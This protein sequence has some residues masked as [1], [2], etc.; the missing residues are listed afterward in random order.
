MLVVKQNVD[1]VV[2]HDESSPQSQHANEK[3]RQAGAKRQL[4]NFK[5]VRFL[6]QENSCQWLE[7]AITVCTAQSFSN[8]LNHY[9]RLTGTAHGLHKLQ[10][11][12]L[13]ALLIVVILILYLSGKENR[14][15]HIKMHHID[16]SP[17]ACAVCAQPFKKR[18][19][20]REHMKI[21]CLQVCVSFFHVAN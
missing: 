21:H 4:H 3:M 14:K 1:T 10:N 5:K 20:V 8:V 12:L 19:T 11:S 15:K 17:F 9:T 7:E 18:Q 6:K 2:L 13:H 16:D